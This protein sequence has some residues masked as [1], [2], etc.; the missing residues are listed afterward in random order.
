MLGRRGLARVIADWRRAAA[1]ARALTLPYHELRLH[2]ALLARTPEPAPQREATRAR[3][4]ELA[5]S[6]ALDL[7]TPAAGRIGAPLALGRSVEIEGKRQHS[8]S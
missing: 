5:D 2:T 1:T 7:E 4:S 3:I 6:I 8:P